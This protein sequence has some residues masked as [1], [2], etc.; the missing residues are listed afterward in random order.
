M[1]TAI[2]ERTRPRIDLAEAQVKVR[3]PL[4]RLRGTIRAY[5]AVEGLT[6]LL[7]YL[8]V[9]FWVLLVLDYGVFKAFTVDWVQVDTHRILRI[10][11]LVGALGGLAAV[12]ILTV[13]LRLFRDFRDAAL[14]LVLERRFPKV[15]GDRLITAVELADTRKAATYGYS[16]VMIEQTIQDAAE[17]VDTVP[18]ND[19]FKWSRLVWRGVLVGVLT[20]GFYLLA[21]LTFCLADSLSAGRNTGL[22]G[23]GQFHDVSVQLIKRDILLQDIIWPR[24]AF[25]DFVNFPED[26]IRI[27]SDAPPPSVR[28]RAWQ[29]VMSDTKTTEGWRGVRL[30]DQ[31]KLLGEEPVGPAQ[32]VDE[33]KARD[34][35]LT[36]PVFIDLRNRMDA[37]LS[38][39]KGDTSDLKRERGRAEAALSRLEPDAETHD[40]GIALWKAAA[41]KLEKDPSSWVTDLPALTDA[42]AKVEK[43]PNRLKPCNN[44][45]LDEIELLLDRPDTHAVLKADQEK[46]LRDLLERFD[47]LAANPEMKRKLRKLEIPDTV[48][49]NYK[50]AKS[51][52]TM[53][54]KKE[55]GNE[56]VG[57]FTDLKETITFTA[58]GLDYYTRTKQITVVPPPA[59]EEMNADLYEPAYRFYRLPQGDR[60]E[61]LKGKKQ[62][63]RKQGVSLQGGD[64]STIQV[65]SGTDV[66]LEAR[67]DKKL[68]ETPKIL[69]GKANSKI[70]FSK[71]EVTLQDDARTFQVQFHDV[72]ETHD[73]IFQFRDTDGVTAVRRVEIVPSPDKPPTVDLIVA[74]LRRTPLGYMITPDAIIPFDGKAVD[75]VALS[76]LQ[77]AYTLTKVDKQSE[78]GGRAVLMLSAAMLLP[79][80]PGQELATA[81]SIASLSK[82]SKPIEANV[83]DKDVRRAPVL[84]FY[85][86]LQSRSSEFLPLKTIL[87]RLDGVSS[88][89]SNL[90]KEFLLEQGEEST[91][92][93]LKNPKHM[94]APLK[95][96]GDR[97]IQPEYV[98]HLWVEA[99]DNDIENGPHKSQVKERLPF[100]IV[101]EEKLVL[102]IGKE[103]EQLYIK[104]KDVHDSV[105]SGQAKLSKVQAGLTDPK[106]TYELFLGMS[107][108]IEKLEQLL[109]KSQTPINEV[110]TDYERIIKE[111][112][113]NRVQPAVLQ[114]R[115]KDVFGNLTIAKDQDGPN[116]I[117]AM[118][119]LR[120]ALDA[121]KKDDSASVI[122]EKALK[123]RTAF[124][125]ARVAYLTYQN[126]IFEALDHMQQMMNIQALIKM[127]RAMEEAEQRSIKIIEEVHQIAQENI[128]GANEPE[129]KDK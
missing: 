69:A 11:A 64:K 10:I 74:V 14:A 81:A 108:E 121:V 120:A 59:I 86:K 87:T 58:R 88:P 26:E 73:F 9:W 37:A 122:S 5:L 124:D 82:E 75:D 72:R 78:Q 4:Q 105:V 63:L 47:E 62:V 84:G 101:S 123:A 2:P 71:Q 50:S 46:A 128:L 66:M 1:A 103:E 52:N 28:L 116:A 53:T 17:R 45:S 15:L 129:K 57:T 98:M 34:F 29:Y 77:F 24:R 95:V 61:D 44:L 13:A 97:E 83:G 85:E 65:P 102:E 60:A 90:L 111:M 119:E 36:D 113:A 22:A 35:S 99:T 23:F 41:E 20:L 55:E 39:A 18:I 43:E 92:F 115:K 109:D 96:S 110:R 112:E 49:V 30:S 3:H 27:G 25:M 21:G 38:K 42:L 80:G 70:D 100:H 107:S 51:K 104:T 54:L 56:Y 16:R 118:S 8:S 76:E 125:Q 7:L 94:P 31:K 93:D 106:P 12:L 127:A 89:P 117:K 32:L 114:P 40:A 19:V 67:T 68:S 79:G 126:R 6:T 48:T 91:G 33:W